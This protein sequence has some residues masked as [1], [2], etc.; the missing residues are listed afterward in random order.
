MS[1]RIFADTNILYTLI[2]KRKMIRVAQRQR[3]WSGYYR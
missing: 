3:S 1:A 2:Y